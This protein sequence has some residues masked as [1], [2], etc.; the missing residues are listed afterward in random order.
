MKSLIYCEDCG[1]KV[2]MNAVT[3]P[4]CGSPIQQQKSAQKQISKIKAKQ[5]K[6]KRTQEQNAKFLN[7]LW[8]VIVL[9]FAYGFLSASFLSALLLT[10]SGL[11]SLWFIKDFLQIKK[12][13]T[14]RGVWTGLSVILF[15]VGFAIGKNAENEQWEKELSENPE[16][17]KQVE[18]ARAERIANEAKE[19]A[20]KE[21]QENTSKAMLLMRC[22]EAIKPSLKNPNSI[23]VDFGG[24][25]YGQIDGKPAVIMHYYAENGF[26][27]TILNKVSCQ[28]DDN[29]RLLKVKPVE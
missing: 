25:Q 29:G 28:F 20:E 5:E 7:L 21:R 3:C 17:A 13:S 26:G 22:E 1:K 9:Y 18:Q 2:S 14:K 23:D 27:A 12:P 24:S 10:A 4:S 8:C 16:L 11:L 15:I 6:D 19:R